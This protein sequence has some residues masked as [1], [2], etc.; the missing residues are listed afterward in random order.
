MVLLVTLF[1]KRTKFGAWFSLTRSVKELF[2]ISPADISRSGAVDFQKLGFVYFGTLIH[3]LACLESSRF[4]SRISHMRLIFKNFSSNWMILV[5]TND[6]N[7]SQIAF[8]SGIVAY[9]VLLKAI[10]AKKPLRWM[11]FYKWLK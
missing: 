3:V 7:F 6:G 9:P 1:F 8:F 11:L 5:V 4:F 10:E 2:T